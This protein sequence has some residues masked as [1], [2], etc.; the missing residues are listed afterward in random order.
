MLLGDNSTWHPTHLVTAFVL[1]YVFK[2]VCIATSCAEG[3]FA[4]DQD[5]KDNVFLWDKDWT[6]L[7]VASYKVEGF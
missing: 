7:L 6:D 2:D 4:S 5:N 1:L 3:R